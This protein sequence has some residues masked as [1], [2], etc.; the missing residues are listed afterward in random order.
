MCWC[1][2]TLGQVV[3]AHLEHEHRALGPL[4]AAHPQSPDVLVAAHAEGVKLE[5]AVL[6]K[7]VE[8]HPTDA[9]LLLAAAEVALQDG[10]AE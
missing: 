1:R 10:R 4:V 3:A 5:P 6:A 9:R 7:A 8:Q 2:L